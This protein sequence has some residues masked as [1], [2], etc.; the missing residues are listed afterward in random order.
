MKHEEAERYLVDLASRSL[1]NET[2][3]EMQRHVQDCDECQEWLETYSLLEASVAPSGAAISHPAAEQIASYALD[4]E[5]V[6]EPFI[7]HVS[8]CG[9]CNRE[10]RLVRASVSQAE[11]SPPNRESWPG[12]R[13]LVAAALS[14]LA[15]GLPFWFSR[16][17]P[18]GPDRTV[19]SQTLYGTTTIDSN[20]YLMA[21]NTRIATGA[22]VT[23]RAGRIVALG[24]GFSVGDDASLTI[25][26]TENLASH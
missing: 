20:E 17:N 4:L 7:A 13:W 2:V 6:D 21:T 12:S 18:A 10:V 25:E 26:V 3:S 16:S 15:F 11:A 23:L 19:S 1:P 22:D 9:N 14:A 5:E 24:D 8:G